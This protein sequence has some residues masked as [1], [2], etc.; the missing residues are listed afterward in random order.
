[1]EEQRF[2]A[3]LSKT[4]ASPHLRRDDVALARLRQQR[5]DRVL[6]RGSFG[7]VPT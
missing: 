7:G 2:L 1:V 5:R 3:P 6:C 4:N